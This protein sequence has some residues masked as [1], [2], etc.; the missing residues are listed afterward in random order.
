MFQRKLRFSSIFEHVT[1][2]TF[3][4]LRE[5]MVSVFTTLESKEVAD[6]S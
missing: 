3:N 4:L 5:N 2:P 6:F 1:K